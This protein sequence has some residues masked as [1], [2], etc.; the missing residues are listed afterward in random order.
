LIYFS[1]LI[2]SKNG[3]IYG[4]ITQIISKR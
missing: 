1:S 3:K 4:N 2:I